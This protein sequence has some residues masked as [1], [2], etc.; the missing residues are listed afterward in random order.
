[1]DIVALIIVLGVSFAFIFGLP[2]GIA[3]I[4]YNYLKRKKVPLYLRWMAILPALI[5]L[6]FLTAWIFPDRHMYSEDFWEITG[7]QFPQEATIFYKR[8]DILNKQNKNFSFGMQTSPESFRAI[9]DNVQRRGFTKDSITAVPD[10]ITTYLMNNNEKVLEQLS[11]KR[12]SQ[13]DY[14]I[15]LCTDS[16]TIF[17]RK[18]Y[19]Q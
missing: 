9:L 12:Y 6:Y 13:Y 10:S 11:L 17:M 8:S 1:M 16:S 7:Y 14:Y 18:E 4:G 5:V 2:F 3:Q 15:E 19:K